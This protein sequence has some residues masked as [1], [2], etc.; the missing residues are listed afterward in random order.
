LK[1]IQPIQRQPFIGEANLKHGTHHNGYNKFNMYE[2][3]IVRTHS[4]VEAQHCN[5]KS[6]VEVHGRYL[7][8]CNIVYSKYEHGSNC[9]QKKK[10]AMA[11]SHLGFLPI[12]PKTQ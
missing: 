8:S 10:E 1:Q 12:V 2:F 3:Q 6:H 7:G 5:Q 11:L 9:N 4:L